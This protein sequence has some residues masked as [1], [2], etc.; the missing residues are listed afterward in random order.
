[1]SLLLTGMS[2]QQLLDTVIDYAKA[3]GWLVTHFRPART[4]RG[5][6]T[7]ISG[8]KGFPDL[9]LVH[10]ELQRCIFAELKA[11]K[12]TLAK[13]Q[14]LWLAGL[15]AAGMETFLWRPTDLDEIRKQLLG[16]KTQRPQ[17]WQ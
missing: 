8:H 1:M 13:E 5:W 9:V 6:S 2:E 15:K 7:P 12:G 17:M 4:S 11:Q 14:K 16:H 10:A 3:G